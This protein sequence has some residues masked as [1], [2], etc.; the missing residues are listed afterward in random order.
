M[1][2]I[3]LFVMITA[4][5]AS[6]QP[7]TGNT[8]GREDAE[9]KRL[10]QGVWVNSDDASPAFLVRDDS[11]YYYEAAAQPAHVWVSGDSLYI[12]A[13]QTR[14]YRIVKQAEHLLKIVNANGEEVKFERPEDGS[15]TATPT[16]SATYAMNLTDVSDLDTIAEGGGRTARVR[17]HTEPTSDRIAKTVYNEYGIE[18]DNMYLDHSAH[19][20]LLDGSRIYYDH[21]F[22]KAEF[23]Q[24]VP[25][26]FLN[27]S[28]LRSID[29]DHRDGSA[30][31][32]TASIGVPDA[33]TCYVVELRIADD[34]QL[35]KRLK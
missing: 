30:T 13:S 29:Y 7:R 23:A 9:A 16:L 10:L 27:A 18:V 2:K 20:I 17:V 8:Q 11:I 14:H 5:L 3:I 25:R 21:T 35:S 15:I 31:Y 1:N 4:L 19:V 26:D 24:L 22:R 28:I 32:L 34:G 33:E 12:E 6:C